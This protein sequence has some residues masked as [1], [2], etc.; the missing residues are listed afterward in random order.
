MPSVCSPTFTITGSAEPTRSTIDSVPGVMFATNAVR[1]SLGSITIWPNVCPVFFSSRIAPVITSTR[2][3]TP[4]RSAVTTTVLL[5]AK[6][7]EPCGRWYGANGIVR[8]TVRAGMS[9]SV[10]VVPAVP[11]P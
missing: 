2:T 9:M 6:N 11:A 7:V 10:S 3:R 8:A 5:S 4:L 1:R